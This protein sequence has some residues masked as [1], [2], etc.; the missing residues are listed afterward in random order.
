MASYGRNFEF[1]IP[2]K[3]SARGGRFA[4]PSTLL[5][6]SGVGGGTA[7]GSTRGAG[8]IPIGAPVVA[9]L[10]AGKDSA[11][12]QIVKLAAPGALITAEPMAGIMVYEYAPAA[13]AGE[14][15]YLT[16]YSDLDAAPLGAAV[17]VIAGDQA[18]KVI[19]T[20]TATNL[21]LGVRS[22]QGRTMVNGLGATPTVAVGDY[23]I[24]GNGNDTDGYWSTTATEAGAWA[25]ITEIDTA[26]AQ[27]AARLL[28]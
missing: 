26:R 21:F 15:P 20:N 5:S 4:A 8:L 10:A 23:L 12:R 28:F 13:F 3:A 11:G 7:A 1:R 2:P 9:D 6:G 14:D 27:V 25:V 17:Q 24:P 18:T 22:Y 19:L 16:T